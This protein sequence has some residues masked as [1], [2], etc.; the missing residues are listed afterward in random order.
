MGGTKETRGMRITLIGIGLATALFFSCTPADPP[1][2]LVWEFESS[3]RALEVTAEQGIWWAG[4]NGLV[5]HSMD[6]GASWQVDTLRLSDGTLP[7]FRS[8][9]VTNEAAFALTI[10]SPAVLFRRDLDGAI[11]D[12]VYVNKDPAIF[13]DSMAFWDDQEGL[14]M[15]DATAECLSVLITR[16]GGRQWNLL[17]CSELPQVATAAS[18]QKEAAFAAS[19]GN[20]VIQDDE[21]WMA[22][23]GVSSRLYYSSDRGKNWSVSN[24]PIMQGGAMTGMFSVARCPDEGNVGMAWG[25]NWEEME[26][27]SANK[28]VSNDGGLQWELLTPN[29][30]PGY[31]SSVQFVPNS[32][33]Q[34]IWAVG[35][36][37][38]SQSWDAGETWTTEADSSYYT[39]RFDSK[40]ETAWLAGRGRVKRMP[41]TRP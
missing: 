12:S 2:P 1:K 9:A 17:D 38:V 23:G 39:V 29:D 25:G 37:G 7:A 18:G 15:G 3:I 4:A 27:N 32:S 20:L 21:V 41:V 14:A 34:G 40:G 35:I 28:I 30:G 33:C 13:F 5:G 24:T 26:D 31:R 22:S 16:D 11:W 36:P 19:N 8:I 10:A 6:D